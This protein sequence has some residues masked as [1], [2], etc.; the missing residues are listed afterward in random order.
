MFTN[1]RCRLGFFEFFFRYTD[2]LKVE[3]NQIVKKFL[4]ISVLNI[5]RVKPIEK[6]FSKLIRILW[7]YMLHSFEASDQMTLQVSRLLEIC[8]A[9]WTAESPEDC[10][11]I[12]YVTNMTIISYQ[13]KIL[14]VH[15]DTSSGKFPNHCAVNK[16]DVIYEKIDTYYVF[17]RWNIIHANF[18]EL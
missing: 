9:S 1:R 5:E 8:I 11:G 4:I 13:L 14:L 18:L 16:I 17:R 6:R 10:M 15:F 2:R 3:N 12:V 7:I